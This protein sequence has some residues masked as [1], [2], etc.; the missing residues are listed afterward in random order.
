[1]SPMFTLYVAD[2]LAPYEN[3]KAVTINFRRPNYSA[4]DG[5]Y[6]LAEIRYQLLSTTYIFDITNIKFWIKILNNNMNPNENEIHDMNKGIFL[7]S[8]E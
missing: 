5:S 4:N 6:H 7:I 3:K 2:L 1:M 8:S